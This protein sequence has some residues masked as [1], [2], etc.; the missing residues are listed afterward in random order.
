MYNLGDDKELDRLSREAAGNYAPPAEPD[1]NAMNRI[2]DEVMPV[3]EKKRRFIIFW[4]LLPLLLIGGGIAYRLTDKNSSP[5]VSKTDVAVLHT[6]KPAT[7]TNTTEPKD[8]PG[9]IKNLA[10]EKQK[11]SPSTD[12]NENPGIA[13]DKNTGRLLQTVSEPKTILNSGLL[14]STQENTA[15]LSTP[16]VSNQQKNSSNNVEQLSQPATGK[17]NTETIAA[18][19]AQQS[20]QAV[21][22]SAETK[23]TEP[24]K[25]GEINKPIEKSVAAETTVETQSAEKNNIVTAS[26]KRKNGFSFSLLAGVD[27]STVKFKY[28]NDAGV[29]LGLMA[30]YHFNDRWSLH[31]GA[32][33][34][35]KNYKLAGEDFTAPKG[36]PISYYKLDMVE[37]YCRMWEVPLL[38]R[39]VLNPSAKNSVFA[40]TGLS[41]YFMTSE[42]YSYYYYYNGQPVSRTN[43]YP[44]SDTHVMAIWDLSLGFQ[45]PLGK[46]WTMQ[47]E[48]YAKL[49][50]SGVGL[51]SIR[52]SSFGINFAAQFRQP[53]N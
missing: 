24:E 49:P 46:N 40:S 18:T 22:S 33:Y 3:E 53:R 35:Q 20:N 16:A 29:N 39:Y 7:E 44:S 1:W 48:P 37:G 27:K 45:K 8:E 25:P 2:L 5:S 31:T 38:M 14:R 26:R 41:S 15:K 6:E 13:S 28:G 42:N 23:V 47:I 12:R 50:L 17:Q 51:G 4:W 11:L 19:T 43:N 9:S 10:P 52:L 36:S 30:G 34:T 21:S 32:I